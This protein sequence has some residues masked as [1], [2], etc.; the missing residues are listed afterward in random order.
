M[1]GLIVSDIYSLKKQ[2]LISGLVALVYL[3]IGIV[4]GN[5]T[6]MSVFLILFATMLPV[7]SFTYNEAC[8]WDMY[9]NTLPVRR[10]DFVGAKFILSLLFMLIAAALSVVSV[11]ISNLIQG[12]PVF[13]DILW[14]LMAGGIGLIY[15]AVFMVLI[16]KFGAERSRMIMML[17][18][19]IPFVLAMYLQKSGKIP[20]MSQLQ[21]SLNAIV[22]MVVLAAL[23]IY[24]IGFVIALGIYKR[25]EL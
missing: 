1:K 3:I 6:S 14:P 2:M 7:T 16:F 25:K 12:V 11:C 4:G 23:V 18:F 21:L 13:Q 9:A 22:G 20:Q 8:H 15:S 24:I 10:F 17:S 5:A 19:L